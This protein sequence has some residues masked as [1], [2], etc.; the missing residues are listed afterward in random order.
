MNRFKTILLMSCSL[1]RKV[2]ATIPRLIQFDATQQ[3]SL[4]G[5]LVTFQSYVNMQLILSM[6]SVEN[7]VTLSFYVNTDLSSVSHLTEISIYQ[8]LHWFFLHI[9]FLP[10]ASP[11][12]QK[13]PS[14][15]VP[16]YSIKKQ[17]YGKK[18]PNHISM[19]TLAYLENG[20]IPV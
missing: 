5:I 16:S 7:I 19:S 3:T 12:W 4:F 8:I 13:V 6:K 2:H 11:K 10:Q 15:S 14:L 20:L 18:N 1:L 17:F 9:F